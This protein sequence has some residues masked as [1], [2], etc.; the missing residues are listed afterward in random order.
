MAQSPITII[1][2][3]WRP[4]G[5]WRQGYT[6]HHVNAVDRMLAAVMKSP[7]RHVCVTD[8]PEGIKCKTIPLWKEPNVR[9]RTGAP[10][11]YKRLFLFSD[12]ARE[13]FG[14]RFV[15][16]DIDCVIL[17]DLTPLFDTGD[18]FKILKGYSAPYNGSMWAMNADAR[19]E[20]WKDFDPRRSPRIAG[21]QRRDDGKF[22]IGSDQA[23]MSYKL[24]GEATWTEEDGVYQYSKIKTV[25]KNARI[26]FFAGSRKP[27]HPEIK[28]QSRELYAR[29]RKHFGPSE[30]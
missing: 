27:W 16:L 21:K 1:T 9:T 20:V 2:W 12:K 15:S 3:L 17:K 24:P 19:P 5:T 14:D 23:W 7:Y 4:T 25:P 30:S 26:V 18:D 11:C 22:V 6:A 29:Y 13:L 28:Q 8:M 10:N